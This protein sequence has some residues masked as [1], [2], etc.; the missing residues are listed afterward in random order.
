MVCWCVV[1]ILLYVTAGM[2]AFCGNASG[3]ML[4]LI[5]ADTADRPTMYCR[6]AAPTSAIGHRLF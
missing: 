2:V 5:K 3:N 4:V 1:L 6:I